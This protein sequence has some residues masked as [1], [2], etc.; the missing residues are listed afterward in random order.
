MADVK[1]VKIDIEVKDKTSK[2]EDHGVDKAKTFDIQDEEEKLP[3]KMILPVNLKSLLT[4]MVLSLL[5]FLVT[6]VIFVLAD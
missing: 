1:K 3:R 4:V 5:E 6:L 2:P